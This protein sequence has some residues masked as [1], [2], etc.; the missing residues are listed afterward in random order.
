[1][2]C[3]ATPFMIQIPQL[4]IQ[5]AQRKRMWIAE[6]H[7]AAN[8]TTEA[9]AHYLVTALATSALTWAMVLLSAQAVAIR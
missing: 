1:M 3:A 4:K 6:A 8:A 2:S 5:L 7:T 9:H